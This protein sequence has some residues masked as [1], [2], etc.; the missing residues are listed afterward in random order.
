MMVFCEAEDCK[1]FKDGECCRGTISL[2]DY[3]ECQD[4]ESYLD[5]AEW[6]KPFWKRMLSKD[7]KEIFRVLFHGKEFEMKGLKLFVE[8]NSDYATV[9]EGTTGLGVGEKHELEKKIDKVIEYMSKNTLTPLEELPIGEYD[10]KTGAVKPKQ[11][12]VK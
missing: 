9:T 10:K 7:T 5:E 2:D 3:K 11:T 8:S 4:F 6:Q 1:W 12:E